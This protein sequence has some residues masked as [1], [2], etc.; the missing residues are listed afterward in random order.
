ME[1]IICVCLLTHLKHFISFKYG[2]IDSKRNSR[3]IHS[4]A[5][6]LSIRESTRGNLFTSVR[7]QLNK[8]EDIRKVPTLLKDNV[9]LFTTE[10]INS[11]GILYMK[12][13]AFYRREEEPEY[14]LS[15][16]PDIYK[17]VVGEISDA[18]SVPLGLYFC[19]HGGDG[20]HTGV[21][22][23]DYVDIEVAYLVVGV[24]FFFIIILNFILPTPSM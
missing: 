20:A 12:E 8:N 24:L 21:A 11:D 22:D 14:A 6:Q 17:K 4:R 5:H 15:V 10:Q 18:N 1:M 3:S 19:C 13:E 23:E 7:S 2:A 16:S 9:R